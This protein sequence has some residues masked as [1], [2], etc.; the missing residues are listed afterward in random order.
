MCVLL[1]DPAFHN[2]TT[3]TSSVQ[4]ST[5]SDSLID[6]P[7]ATVN[8][9][10]PV[11][12]EVI[13]IAVADK[14]NITEAE[15]GHR[16]GIS[17]DGVDE[18][19]G[20]SK[21]NGNAAN[22]T[23][24][25]WAETLMAGTHTIKGRFSNNRP[26]KSDNARVDFRTLIIPSTPL[27]PPET[28]K[29]NISTTVGGTTEPVPGIYE[30]DAGTIVTPIAIAES[31]YLF[32]SWLLDGNVATDNPISVLMD[33]DHVLE[34]SFVPIPPVYHSLTIISGAGGTTEPAP[35]IYTYLEGTA[36]TVVAV[37]DATYMFSKW[38]LDGLEATEN[39]I[40]VTMDADH[41]LEASFTLPTCPACPGCWPNCWWLLV[42]GLVVGGAGTYVLTREDKETK[43]K[44][45]QI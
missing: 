23:A 37:P 32:D 33:R 22:S 8:I 5:T 20:R 12:S 15:Y 1:L 10:L 27:P 17:I 36:V 16:Y 40:T 43:T 11:D 25:I 2:L 42:L 38:I 30:F 21:P 45:K 13:I 35:S 6:D 41:I 14:R 44:R 26:G 19:H 34:A 31:G 18:A 28:Y 39:P 24:V 29:L 9:S 7:Q 4:A 3:L